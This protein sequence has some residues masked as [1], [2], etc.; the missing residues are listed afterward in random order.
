MR[1]RSENRLETQTWSTPSGKTPSSLTVPGLTILSHPEIRRTGE[2]AAL[3][4]LSS[5]R[6]SLLSRGEPGFAPPGDSALQPLAV[7]YLSR[8]PWL[9]QPTAGGGVRLLRG[10]SP[11]SLAANDGPV[12]SEAS[13]SAGGRLPRQSGRLPTAVGSTT[14]VPQGTSITANHSWACCRHWWCLRP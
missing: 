8:R 14:P 7:P 9:L 13:F 1:P 10:D 5:G 12:D 4:D 2:R 6:E 11:M 3:L